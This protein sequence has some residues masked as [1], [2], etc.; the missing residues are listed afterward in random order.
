MQIIITKMSRH[1][2][3][4]KRTNSKILQKGPGYWGV[5]RGSTDDLFFLFF[6]WEEPT[7]SFGKW[8]PRGRIDLHYFNSKRMR[9]VLIYFLTFGLN[10]FCFHFLN[11]GTLGM[12]K[13]KKKVILTHFK[14]TTQ[15][16]R[17]CVRRIRMLFGE[18]G[19]LV[20]VMPKT[21]GLPSCS[22]D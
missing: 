19:L 20:M 3:H 7:F 12:V 22:L 4:S 11:S 2:S 10:S 1:L 15:S 17:P 16:S 8:P 6:S 21:R 13:E 14:Q 5:V 18:E 9:T